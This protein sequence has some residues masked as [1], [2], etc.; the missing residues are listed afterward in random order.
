MTKDS[1]IRAARTFAMA[2]AVLFI[3]GLLG[4]LNDLTAWASS[5]GQQP[6]PSL[7]TLEYLGVSAIVAGGIA[8][9]N[10]VWNALED[11][12][13]KTAL[14]GKSPAVELSAPITPAGVCE[15][16]EKRSANAPATTPT[17]AKKTTARRPAKKTTKP[18][19]GSDAK[20]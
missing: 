16:A 3:P 11:A 8:V 17:P 12:T 20:S 9:V 5:N 10:L 6:F 13:G 14:R 18:E 7:S 15:L 4:W 19:P 1:L 2:F